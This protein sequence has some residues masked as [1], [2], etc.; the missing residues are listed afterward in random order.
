[1]IGSANIDIAI[2]EM[3][4]GIPQ[5][6]ASMM[7]SRNPHR[8]F[9]ASG[10]N[11]DSNGESNGAAAAPS[12]PPV[13]SA[14][15]VLQAGANAASAGKSAKGSPIPSE[16]LRMEQARIEEEQRALNETLWDMEKSEKE[17]W[18][19][20]TL[21][22]YTQMTVPKTAYKQP[23]DEDLSHH[24]AKQLVA[25]MR[26]KP[27]LGA[28]ASSLLGLMS[29]KVTE[30]RYLIDSAGN[31]V[32]QSVEKP[33]LIIEP[34]RVL[35]AKRYLVS[36]QGNAFKELVS[37]VACF[38]H[39]K[40]E[41]ERKFLY[42]EMSDEC[43]S[44]PQ[45]VKSFYVEKT[46]EDQQVWNC[47]YVDDK[48]TDVIRNFLEAAPGGHAIDLHVAFDSNKFHMLDIADI[49]EYCAMKHATEALAMTIEEA[50]AAPSCFQKESDAAYHKYWN[51]YRTPEGNEHRSCRMLFPKDIS[52]SNPKKFQSGWK[53]ELAKNPAKYSMK[54]K[55]DEMMQTSD[56]YAEADA[57]AELEEEEERKQ[58]EDERE[59]ERAA[60]ERYRIERQRREAVAAEQTRIV[61]EHSAAK[62]RED[63]AAQ[64]E[65][66]Q[67]V[68]I[69]ERSSKKID[70]RSPPSPQPLNE[71]NQESTS[72][73]VKMEIEPREEEDEENQNARQRYIEEQLFAEY[74]E[75]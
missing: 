4:N 46:V 25:K 3:D 58:E 18:M 15:A 14:F 72:T 32:L 71:N 5:T 51:E 59:R 23:T 28:V 27:M 39:P 74:Q 37:T 68:R 70:M 19:Y 12:A 53:E 69:P 52:K 60:N 49:D 26:S 50:R 43:K 54:A 30:K 1:M 66:E 61:Q 10:V 17:N 13:K 20:F 36:M 62:I 35:V 38:F 11:D 33:A 73:V 63:Q 9:N 47:N 57:E 55:Q 6:E 29:A 24:L 21:N 75:S 22:G 45:R 7:E 42:G 16:M 41:P 2:A 56:F 44:V 65:R 64:Q 67:Q 48:T 34:H 8:K 40:G 31:K